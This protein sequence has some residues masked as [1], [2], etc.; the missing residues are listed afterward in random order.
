MILPCRTKL[1]VPALASSSAQYT[2]CFIYE[3]KLETL[4]MNTIMFLPTVPIF[5]SINENCNR[6]G[7]FLQLWQL[8]I[9][10]LFT[11]F[12]TAW[13]GSSLHT[14]PSSFAPGWW[15]RHLETIGTDRAQ[16]RTIR[17]VIGGKVGNRAKK[18]VEKKK[19]CRSKVQL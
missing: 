13:K 2:K 5:I 15:V 9:V 1:I 12:L 16:G 4:S 6:T 19:S 17:K 14:C 3:L 7:L 18:K 10:L 8:F 11:F